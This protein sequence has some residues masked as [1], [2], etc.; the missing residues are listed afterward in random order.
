[1]IRGG[2]WEFVMGDPFE[3]GEFAVGGR[4]RFIFSEDG[5]RLHA[6]DYEG[7]L[8]VTPVL[9]LPG[10]ART[11]LD[12]APL[13][14]SLSEGRYGRSRRTVALDYR[15]RGLSDWDPNG[16]YDLLVE[17]RDILAIIAALGLSEAFIVGTSRGGLHAMV[18]ASASPRLLRGVVLNDVGPRLETQGLLRIRSYLGKTPR[19]ESLDQASAM[20]RERMGGQF[21]ALNEADWRWFAATTFGWTPRG[22]EARYDPRL[23]DL[24][25]AL[26]LTQP[27][28]ELWPQFEG[29][30]HAPIL[31]LRGERSDLLSEKTLTEMAARHPNLVAHVAPGQGHAPLLS[32][33]ETIRLIAT[34]FDRWELA[35]DKGADNRRA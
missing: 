33:P 20:L 24:L 11:H 17:N 18:F 35:A 8:D 13:A 25:T 29:L 12:F 30:A 27:L 16:A 10:L 2:A 21:P 1:M 31:A 32:D 3:T 7:G 19:C 26:D 34:T 28:P 6:R 4:S 14:Q 9:C 15:G 22:L 5:V 23:A